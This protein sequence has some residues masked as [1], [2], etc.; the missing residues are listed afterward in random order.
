VWIF[1]G[2]P[3]IFRAVPMDSPSRRVKT[4]LTGLKRRYMLSSHN[5]K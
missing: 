5:V 2:R 4:A 3:F 1:T